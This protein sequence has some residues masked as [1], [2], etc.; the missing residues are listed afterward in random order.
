MISVVVCRPGCEGAWEI[1]T[2]LMSCRVLRRDVEKFMLDCVLDAGGNAS[3]LPDQEISS[4]D[5]RVKVLIIRAQE[6]WAI[7][8]ACRQIVLS[9]TTDR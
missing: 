8:R 4:S 1:D 2:W 9:L 5:S 6:D 3:S 7:A